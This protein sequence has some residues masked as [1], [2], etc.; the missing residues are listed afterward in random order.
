VTE[1]ISN[2]LLEEKDFAKAYETLKIKDEDYHLVFPMITK[3]VDAVNS[4]KDGK[5]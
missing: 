4:V 3:V 1:D 5:E 2:S